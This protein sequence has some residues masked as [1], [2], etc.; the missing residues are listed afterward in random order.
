MFAGILDVAAALDPPLVNEWMNE[1][2]CHQIL[3]V[4]IHHNLKTWEGPTERRF[5]VSNNN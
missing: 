1:W 4:Q 5:N 2:S 3:P